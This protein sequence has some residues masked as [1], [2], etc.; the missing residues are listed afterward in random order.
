[1]P[2]RADALHLPAVR[3]VPDLRFAHAQAGRQGQRPLQAGQAAV[4]GYHDYLAL[5]AVIGILVAWWL[6]SRWPVWRRCRCGAQYC[7]GCNARRQ[8]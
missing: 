8:R 1:M 5:L 4:S 3:R 2:E 6:L 7:T